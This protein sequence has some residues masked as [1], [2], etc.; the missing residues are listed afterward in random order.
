MKPVAEGHYFHEGEFQVARAETI[1]S[2]TWSEGPPKSPARD[3]IDQARHTKSTQ[4]LL[5]KS[6][7]Q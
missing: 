3:L 7:N 4:K 5:V 6:P 2:K 1:P